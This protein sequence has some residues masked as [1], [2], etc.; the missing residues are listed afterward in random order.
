MSTHEWCVD[1]KKRRAIRDRGDGSFTYMYKDNRWDVVVV[2]TSGSITSITTSGDADYDYEVNIWATGD[3]SHTAMM[4]PIDRNRF[5]DV[6]WYERSIHTYITDAYNQASSA[7]GW[8]D[9]E[10]IYFLAGAIYG[11]VSPCTSLAT[12]STLATEWISGSRS[13]ICYT[14]LSYD[15]TGELDVDEI[16]EEE[17]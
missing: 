16:I 15:A 6:M 1:E 12:A 3:H 17:E 9:E 7:L 2:E 5:R 10:K 4:S 14:E 13:D 11:I 8:S